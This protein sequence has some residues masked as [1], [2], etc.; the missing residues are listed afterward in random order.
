VQVDLHTFSELRDVVI[1]LRVMILEQSSAELPS[2]Q[3]C[4][5]AQSLNQSIET[6]ISQ[7]IV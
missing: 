7:L 2:W 6:T 3:L 5:V 4:F 1:T